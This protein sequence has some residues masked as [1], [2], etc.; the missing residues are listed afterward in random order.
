MSN[1]WNCDRA[2]AFSEKDL[3]T[4]LTYFYA[5]GFMQFSYF[6]DFPIFYPAYDH[7]HFAIQSLRPLIVKGLNY[8]QV[9]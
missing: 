8:Q 2:L 4:P 7:T 9:F 3:D 5:P 1:E 6:L